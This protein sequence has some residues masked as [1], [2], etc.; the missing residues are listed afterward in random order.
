[1]NPLLCHET[2]STCIHFIHL[3]IVPLYWTHIVFS[4]GTRV[5]RGDLR[6]RQKRIV[7]W[8]FHATKK[9]IY[10]LA[11]K[12]KNQ[13][14]KQPWCQKREPIINDNYLKIIIKL[15]EKLEPFSGFVTYSTNFGKLVIYVNHL[16]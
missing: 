10:G 15:E 7:I 9:L 3:F 11:I 14:Y 13:E 6:V 2:S 12:T 1:M 16:R 5:W 8:Q 4:G